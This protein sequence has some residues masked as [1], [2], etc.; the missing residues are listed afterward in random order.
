MND[1]LFAVCITILA[2]LAGYIGW[3][4]DG[5]YIKQ[6]LLLYAGAMGMLVMMIIFK[7]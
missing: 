1:K 5:Y 4:G 7:D 6:A 3:D 2:I